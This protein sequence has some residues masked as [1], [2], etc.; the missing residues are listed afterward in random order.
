VLPL[1]AS[2]INQSLSPDFARRSLTV[3]PCDRVPPLY[4]GTTARQSNDNLRAHAPEPAGLECRRPAPPSPT[5]SPTTAAPTRALCAPTEP[6]RLSLHLE[7]PANLPPHL[8]RPATPQ[9]QRRNGG[10]QRQRAHGGSWRAHERP[11]PRP[12]RDGLWRSAQPSEQQE[13]VICLVTWYD[14]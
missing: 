13:C 4:R 14:Y 5:A 2:D 10:S 8:A 11:R 6:A 12:P 9:L 3:L 7:P 1:R